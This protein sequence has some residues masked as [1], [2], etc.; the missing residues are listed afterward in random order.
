MGTF[1]ALL[2]IQLLLSL[3]LYLILARRIERVRNVDDAV[4]RIR[5]EVGQI[6]TE[7]NQTTD[8]NVTLIE[9]RIRA[10]RLTL[11][12]ADRRILDARTARRSR[13]V[14]G[15]A[16]AIAKGTGTSALPPSSGADTAASGGDAQAPSSGET[17]GTKSAAP[18][19]DRATGGGVT[20]PL[21][22]TGDKGTDAASGG[23][24]SQ[25]GTTDTDA[26]GAEG[27]AA[28]VQGDTVG[29]TASPPPTRTRVLGMY[30]NGFDT[31]T[32]AQD[33]GISVGEV[34]LIVSLE[35]ARRN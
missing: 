25:P 6:V 12:D 5:A 13:V 14:P 32:I 31:R 22:S 26:G 19:P 28:S 23:G 35:T 1:L 10:L 18:A 20:G 30:R 29:T 4:D 21:P 17:S 16:G 27:N 9:D 24:A 2:S 33:L 7:L 34:E 8:R 3:G 15:V 11:A